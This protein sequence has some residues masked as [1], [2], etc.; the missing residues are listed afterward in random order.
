MLASD[1]AEILDTAASSK[2]G[3]SVP[4]VDKD[5]S[6]FKRFARKVLDELSGA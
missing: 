4:A 5:V 3:D 1:R 2:D 6:N